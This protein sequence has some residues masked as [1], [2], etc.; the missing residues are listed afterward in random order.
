MQ[1]RVRICDA[2]ENVTD[3][4]LHLITP[5]LKPEVDYGEIDQLFQSNFD[6]EKT[7]NY[8][9]KLYSQIVSIR[10]N[11]IDKQQLLNDSIT[12]EDRIV[13]EQSIARNSDK[14]TEMK[15]RIDY[16]CQYIMKIKIIKSKICAMLTE[17][18]NNYRDEMI[19]KQNNS[20]RTVLLALDNMLHEMTNLHL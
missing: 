13:I 16:F 17:D 19:A 8:F 2:T 12:P 15:Q 18:N 6:L 20:Y 7:K 9:D 14:S 10:Q 1:G 11:N 5:I 3:I 4:K